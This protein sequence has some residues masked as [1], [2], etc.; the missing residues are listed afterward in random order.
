MDMLQHLDLQLQALRH[1]QQMVC[2]QSPMVTIVFMQCPIRTV[3]AI[4]IVIP[5]VRDHRKIA[6]EQPVVQ[7]QDS[8]GRL[9]R[10]FAT[11]RLC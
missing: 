3:A 5:D 1:H 11:F 8:S 4:I 7:H 6:P 2:L 10:C 9:A